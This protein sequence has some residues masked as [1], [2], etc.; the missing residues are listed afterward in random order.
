MWCCHTAEIN[1]EVHCQL[2]CQVELHFTA[3]PKWSSG[4]RMHQKTNQCGRSFKIW[5]LKF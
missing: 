5:E 2:S 3:L 1:L 4:M